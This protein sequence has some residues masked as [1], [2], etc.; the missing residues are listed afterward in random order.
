MLFWSRHESKKVTGMGHYAWTGCRIQ[1][2]GKATDALARQYPGCYQSTVG[3]LKKKKFITIYSQF[4]K[5]QTGH[6][7]FTWA[8]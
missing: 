5:I 8:V 3:S 6:R 2:A 4:H 1:E 7:N